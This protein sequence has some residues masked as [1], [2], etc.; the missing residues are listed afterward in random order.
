MNCRP[1]SIQRLLC[2]VGVLCCCPGWAQ[3][4]KVSTSLEADTTLWVGEKATLTVE[5]LAPGYFYSAVSFDLPDP[6]GVLL[7]PPLGHPIVSGK[8]IDDTYYTV[9]QYELSAY[10]MRAGR[11]SIPAIPVRFSFKHAPLDT[12]QIAA[13]VTT[14]PMPFTVEEPP[15]AENLGQVISARDLKIEETWQPEPGKTSVPAGAAFT[16]TITFT[17]PEVPGMVFPPFPAGRIDGLGIYTKRQVLDRTDD[18]SLRGER[19][20]VITYVCQRPGDFTIPAVR[21]IWFDLETKQLITDDLPERTLNVSANPA[22]ATP[23]GTNSAGG[24]A[25]RIAPRR[26]LGVSATVILLVLFAGWRAGLRR[27]LADLL[28]PLRP[29]HLE[30]L[31]PLE[32]SQQ[33]KQT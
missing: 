24:H 22:L 10:P 33:Q 12:N 27:L 29:I 20:D 6:H 8:T 1:N 7:M 13:T 31:N 26:A 11:Q 9:Q 23:A 3:E 16:R 21:F 15:G 2:L 5:V 28:N 14:T 30:P 4:A 32:Q 25:P 19:R 17:A 18:G